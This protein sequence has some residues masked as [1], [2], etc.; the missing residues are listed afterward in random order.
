MTTSINKHGDD[1][2]Y[3]IIATFKS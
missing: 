3:D 1:E 2:L